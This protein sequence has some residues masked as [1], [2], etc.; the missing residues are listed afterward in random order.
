MELQGEPPVNPE[1][2]EAFDELPTSE[3]LRDHAQKINNQMQVVFAFAD[4]LDELERTGHDSG[5]SG[6]PR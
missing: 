1:L 6:V 3:E 4:Y 2:K 5:G